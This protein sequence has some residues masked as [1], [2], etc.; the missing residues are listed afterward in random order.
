MSIIIKV[1]RFYVIDVSQSGGVGKRLSRWCTAPERHSDRKNSYMHG[2]RL[3]TYH[4]VGHPRGDYYERL[5]VPPE[6]FEREMN[7][8]RRLGFDFMDP[9]KLPDSFD[10]AARRWRRG[11]I[12]TFD[13][14]YAE[15]FEHAFPVL[16]RYNLPAIMYVV[17][18]RSY[19]DWRDWGD[20][21]APRLISWDKLRVMASGGISIG[22]HTRTHV[23]LTECTQSELESEVKDSKK[24]I[25]DEIGRPVRHFCYPYGYYNERVKDVVREAGYETACTTDRGLVT[26]ST[27]TLEMPRLGVG[28]RMTI[29]HFCRRMILGG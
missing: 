16:Q 9:C 2:V 29:T 27:E 1:F 5:T 11:A 12:P 7:V 6:R 8:M 28:K 3:L 22:S 18:D 14:G 13:D 23:D 25:E 26:P 15:V 4:R 17:T 19:A 21:D 10:R 20:N 24:K